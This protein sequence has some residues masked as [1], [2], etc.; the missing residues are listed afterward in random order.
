MGEKSACPFCP[1]EVGRR[2]PLRHGP[3]MEKVAGMSD[4]MTLFRRNPSLRQ[5][6]RHALLF[7]G[8][9][10]DTVGIQE[11]FK[12][13]GRFVTAGSGAVRSGVDKGHVPA[14]VSFFSWQVC[15]WLVPDAADGLG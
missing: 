2:P 8:D 4:S 11:R 9:L 14:P 7:P 10:P 12:Q 6:M 15:R 13:P 5:G 3:A 1:P